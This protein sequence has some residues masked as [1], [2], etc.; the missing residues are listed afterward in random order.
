MVRP[1]TGHQGRGETISQLGALHYEIEAQELSR[2]RNAD[3]CPVRA[4]I[5]AAVAP[6]F[7]LDVETVSD[8]RRMLAAEPLMHNELPEETYT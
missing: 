7:G 6:L 8:W 2:L 3:T 4:A 1:R 5:D